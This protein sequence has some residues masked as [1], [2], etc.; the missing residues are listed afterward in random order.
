MFFNFVYQFYRIIEFYLHNI[1][2]YKKINTKKECLNYKKLLKYQIQQLKQIN[3]YQLIQ[4]FSFFP[5]KNLLLSQ[6]IQFDKASFQALLY[7]QD[8]NQ[9]LQILNKTMIQGIIK[10]FITIICLIQI[11]YQKVIFIKISVRLLIKMLE[12]NKLFYFINYRYF[13]FYRVNKLYLIIIYDSQS[14]AG[15]QKKFLYQLL[16]N[17]ISFIKQ[18]QYLVYFLFIY[19]L[20]NQLILQEQLNLP[21][22]AHLLAE[23]WLKISFYPNLTFHFNN[24]VYFIQINYFSL[25]ANFSTDYFLFIYFNSRL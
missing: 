7:F 25:L 3:K 18:Q 13:I 8:L 4:N 1:F 11:Y 10:G 14:L 5:F 15:Q 16:M 20:V 2:H 21:N 24:A 17:I 6:Q 22:W 12:I 19:Q 23:N 9:M